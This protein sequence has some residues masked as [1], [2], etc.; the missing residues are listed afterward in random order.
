M[1]EFDKVRR[2]N[3][4][5]KKPTAWLPIAISATA[6]LLIA[7]YIAIFGAI[8]SEPAGDEGLIARIFQLLMVTQA[9]IAIF[10][11]VKWLPKEP[12]YTLQIFILQ[13]MVALVPF[14][15]I[16]FLESSS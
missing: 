15:T 2:M 5:I 4:L 14:L 11:V 13:I 10:F 6:L 16:I 1:R 9:L 7:G 3:G 12:R 8:R